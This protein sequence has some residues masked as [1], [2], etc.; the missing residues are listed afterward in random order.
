MGSSITYIQYSPLGLRL[1][2]PDCFDLN[3]NPEWKS[4][5]PDSGARVDAFLTEDLAHRI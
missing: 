4:V 5:G 3:G 2:L 1:D